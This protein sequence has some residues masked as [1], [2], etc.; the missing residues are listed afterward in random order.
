MGTAL[1][2]DI[3]VGA[4]AGYAGSLAMDRATTWYWDRM[5]EQAKQLERDANPDGTPLSVGRTFAPLLGRG[6]SE[7]DAYRTAGQLH[8]ALGIT[9][10]IKAAILSRW[11]M[12]PMAAGLLSGA[13]A[14]VVVD[15][16]VMSVLTAPPSAYPK[17]SHLRGVVGHL[18]L[19]ATVGA[20]LS[21][22]RRVSR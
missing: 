16:G 10:G 1:A 7:A 18:T 11:G 19:G 3:A 14:F 4:L 15:E 5:S 9:Y 20:V 6:D 21:A 13:G 2:R 17:E 12:S 22:A 8:R